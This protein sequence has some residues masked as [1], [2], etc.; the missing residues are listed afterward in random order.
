[1]SIRLTVRCAKC[2]QLALVDP[3]KGKVLRHTTRFYGRCSMSGVVLAAEDVVKLIDV[4][5][6]ETMQNYGRLVVDA[7]SSRASYAAMIANAKVRS[8]ELANLRA[9]V[10]GE[11]TARKAKVKP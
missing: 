9:K 5:Q 3:I 11:K 1:M 10:L 8:D 4:A 6:R 7:E 2:N